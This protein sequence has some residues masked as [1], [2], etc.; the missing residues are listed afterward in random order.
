LTGFAKFPTYENDWKKGFTDQEDFNGEM[1]Y[2]VGPFNM[3]V[4][5][6]ITIIFVQV[7]GYRLQGI[8]SAQR[9][10]E[11][12]WGKNWNVF[13]ELPAAPDIKIE[14]TSTGTVLVRW[15]DSPTADGY[16]IWKASQYK[17]LRYQDLGI[18]LLDRYQEQQTV[19]EDVTKYLQPINPNFDA[20]SYIATE[21]GYQ[22]DNWGTYDL[23]AV[24]PKS[25]V[26]QYANTAVTGFNYAYEDK[27]TVLGFRYW[28]YVS[29]YKDGSFSGPANSTATRIE[30]SNFT[31]NGADGFWKGTFPFATDAAEFP[32][33]TNTEGLRRIGAAFVARPPLAP[34]AALSAGNIKVGVRPNPYKRA[35]YFD[36]RQNFADHK[37]AFYNLPADCKITIVDVSGQLI[38]V[39]KINNATDGLYF[40]NMFSKDGIEVAS[41]VYMYLVEWSGGSTKGFFS[42]LR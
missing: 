6:T 5:E 38:D 20:Y 19:G 35:A 22:P 39:V 1:F 32:A 24:I 7:G 18:R 4:N 25:Q 30:T 9:A 31:R 26:S 17:R 10:A 16:K 29:A 15:T 41:G 14:N 13:P 21:Q 27:S 3:D 37:I 34:T 42:I 12:A 23:V 11:W 8:Q 2:G 28:Y 40:W 36:N 33:A